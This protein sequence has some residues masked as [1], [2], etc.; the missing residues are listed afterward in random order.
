MKRLQETPCDTSHGSLWYLHQI[1]SREFHYSS[2]FEC[3]IRILS[4]WLWRMS[5]LIS[6]SM[7]LVRNSL[8]HYRTHVTSQQLWNWISLLCLSG[9]ISISLKV[10]LRYGFHNNGMYIRSQRPWPLTPQIYT[11]F[12]R[13]CLKASQYSKHQDSLITVV[14]LQCWWS[15]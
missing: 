11:N 3:S 1:P 9:Q 13:R 15:V 8:K 6:S 2:Y 5:R 12:T 4:L 10:L 14:S 7:T